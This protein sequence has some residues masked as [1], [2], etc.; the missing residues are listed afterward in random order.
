MT[1]DDKANGQKP[2]QFRLVAGG[3][4]RHPG[5]AHGSG[6]AGNVS[7]MASGG[8]PAVKPVSIAVPAL[9]PMAQDDGVMRRQ[10]AERNIRNREENLKRNNK[11]R[12]KAKVVQGFFLIAF[13]GGLLAIDHFWNEFFPPQ[14]QK[15]GEYATMRP[16]QAAKYLGQKVQLENLRYDRYEIL[17]CPAYC[18]SKF[19][20]DQGNG[21]WLGFRKK[22]FIKLKLDDYG[23][24]TVRGH[25]HPEIYQTPEG[26]T[27]YLVVVKKMESG[28]MMDIRGIYRRLVNLAL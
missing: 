5:P 8:Q 4:V 6:P 28:G 19:S 10:Q 17:K 16:Y 3:G 25:V 27:S 12:I 26:Q 14:P 2:L 20:D 23:R 1:Q 24:V 9:A 7:P 18:F 22:S 13:F 11:A 15:L 21:V